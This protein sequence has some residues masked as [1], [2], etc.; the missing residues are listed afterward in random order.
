M[1]LASSTPYLDACCEQD[2]K[3]VAIINVFIFTIKVNAGNMDIHDYSE[4]DN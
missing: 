3:S 1:T 4:N 2:E